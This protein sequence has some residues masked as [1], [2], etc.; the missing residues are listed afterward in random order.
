MDNKRYFA[1]GLVAL[2]C[3]SAVYAKPSPWSLGVGAVYSPKVYRGTPTNR[4]VIPIIGYEGKHFFSRG[5][6]NGYRINPP[7][8][9]HNFV[10][11]AVYDPRGYKPK[12]S[13]ITEMRQL[14]KRDTT[15]LAGVSY[16][17]MAPFGMLEASFGG[18]ILGVHNGVYGEV[19]W[20]LPLRFGPGGIIPSVGYSYNDDKLNQHLYG[21]SQQ[22][23]DRTGG[24]IK[25]FDINGSGRYFVGLF[26][27][28][29]VT[30]NIRVNGGVRYTNLEG[31]IEKSPILDSTVSTIANV[32]ISYSF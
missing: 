12:D 24:S 7:R 4:T 11:R 19:A 17:Y 32:G 10:I 1:V 9:K 21:V 6:S 2:F 18:D 13:S 26:G 3:S 23:S 22:E 29:S 27:Y 15:V 5:F 25:A 30:E 14:S 28:Y 16:Q 31:D 20:R 8:S